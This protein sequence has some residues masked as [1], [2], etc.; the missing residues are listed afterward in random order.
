MTKNKVRMPALRAGT[1]GVAAILAVAVVCGLVLAGCASAPV[2]LSTVSTYYVRNNGKDK[3]AGVSEQKPFKTLAKA[4]EAASGSTVKTITVLGTLTSAMPEITNTGA[5]ILITGKPDAPAVLQIPKEG[6][7][8]I[9]GEDSRIRFE[10]ITITG[11]ELGGITV[12]EGAAVTLGQGAVVSGNSREGGGGIGVYK[13]GALVMSGNALVTKNLAYF[14]GGIAVFGTLLM[15]DDALVSENDVG[16]TDDGKDGEGGGVYAQD[17]EVTL[18]GN[19]AIVK[20]SG[21]WGG[22]IYIN[23]K[24]ALVMRGSASIRENTIDFMAP[25]G[26]THIGGSGGGVCLLGSLT[27]QETSVISGNEAAYGGGIHVD[28]TGGLVMEDRSVVKDNTASRGT[29]SDGKLF[30]GYGGGVNLNGK[31]TMRGE[32]SLSGNEG[33]FGGGLRA[34]SDAQ[35]VLE[36]RASIK[37]N[38]A[39][40]NT[41]KKYGGSGGGAY[42]VGTLLLKDDVEVAD[43][44]AFWGG[45]VRLSGTLTLEGKAKITG[46]STGQYQGGGV[47]VDKGGTIIGDWSLISGNEAKDGPDIFTVLEN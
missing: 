8:F 23:A 44:S 47:Y 30:G 5:E 6:K 10:H 25:K 35:A 24:S 33:L 21:F 27:M 7:A 29:E 14:G 41:E 38:S 39:T 46:N 22:G 17:A 18:E 16:M 36:G 32:S 9:V 20:N 13:G 42:V 15:K 45:G 11:G 37:K 4:I 31:L 12:N 2:D 40:R 34:S 28:K 1:V 26:S 19:A 3:N 43:N